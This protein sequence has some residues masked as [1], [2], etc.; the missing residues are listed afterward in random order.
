MKDYI[1]MTDSNSE[2]PLE[3]VKK[4][5]VPFVRMPYYLDGEEYYYDLGENTDIQDFFR[6][7]RA[8]SVPTTT[9]YPPQH[10][11]DLFE[12]YLQEG[13]DILFIAFSS[14]LSN[15]FEFVT[16]AAESV[17]ERYPGRR[18]ELVDTKSISGGMALLVYKALLLQEQGKTI[19]EVKKWVEDNIQRANEYFSVSDLIYLKRGGRISASVAAVG[20]ML[21]VKP[22]LILSSHGTIVSI[23][24]AKG[25]KKSIKALAEYAIQRAEDPGKNP[26]IIMH[27]D[28]EEDALW[29][30]SLIEEQIHFNEYFIQQLGP[31]I[32]THAGPDTL[33]VCF[34]G[35]VRVDAQ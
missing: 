2:L 28:C 24:K 25:R 34:F 5:N 30:K 32:G 12:P 7:M 20:T 33:G 15:A 29:L 8:G 23:E 1:I 27:G 31:V 35:K 4:Y 16:A 6:R 3:I 22:I 18:V 21:N 13:K 26:C 14:R 9:T 19:D 17:R 10:Y 11:I